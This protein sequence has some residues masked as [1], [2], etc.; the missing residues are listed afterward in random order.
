MSGIGVA[1]VVLALTGLGGLAVALYGAY[2]GRRLQR[3]REHLDKTDALFRE[4]SEYPER[5]SKRAEI[6]VHLERIESRQR[7]FEQKFSGGGR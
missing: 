1:L 3:A 4:F 7:E 5:F 2:Q 6:E